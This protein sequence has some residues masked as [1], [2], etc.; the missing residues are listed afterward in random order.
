MYS[1]NWCSILSDEI[2]ELAIRTMEADF[3]PTPLKTGVPFT[4]LEFVHEAGHLA[5][6]LLSEA[7]LGLDYVA[8]GAVECEN[9]LVDEMAFGGFCCDRYAIPGADWWGW[10]DETA[11][12]FGG[13]ES[14]LVVGCQSFF[15]VGFG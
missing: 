11:P 1:P 8:A 3:S 4:G 14:V 2:H 13:P 6:L 10:V 12:G 5:A 9:A 15:C 7:E